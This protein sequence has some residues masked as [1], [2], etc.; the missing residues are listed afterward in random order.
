MTEQ[1]KEL[2]KRMLEEYLLKTFGKDSLQCSEKLLELTLYML[3]ANERFN[4]TSITNPVDIVNKHLIDSIA[5]FS[6]LGIDRG[7]SIID[8]GSGGG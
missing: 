7:S 5:P 2:M 3:E 1:D 6:V 4:I 8:I